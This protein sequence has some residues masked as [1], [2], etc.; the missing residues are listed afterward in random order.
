MSYLGIGSEHVLVGH[1]NRDLD[2]QNA[3]ERNK[4]TL[5]VGFIDG[6][7]AWTVNERYRSQHKPVRSPLPFP[8][9]DR[10]LQ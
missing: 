2:E 8:H 7:T 4:W 10:S 9:S 1:N 3:S 6:V 5:H